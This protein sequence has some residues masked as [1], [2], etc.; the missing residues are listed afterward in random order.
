M[1]TDDGSDRFLAQH[2]PCCDLIGDATCIQH[3]DSTSRTD[4]KHYTER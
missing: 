2:L 3:V 4:R 1:Q